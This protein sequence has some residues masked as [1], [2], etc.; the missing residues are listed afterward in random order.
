MTEP[1][2]LAKRVAGMLRCSRREAELHI[3]AGRVM[4]DGAVVVEPQFRV[5]GQH[6]GLAADAGTAPPEPVTLLLHRPAGAEAVIAPG[7]LWAGDAS[8]L[9]PAGAYAVPL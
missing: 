3:T 5:A 4:V 6:V 8:G 1:V 7:N 2:R 9:R